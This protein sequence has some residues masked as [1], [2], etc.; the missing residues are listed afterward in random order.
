VIDMNLSPEWSARLASE[1][2][3]AV[4]WRDVGSASASDDAIMDWAADEDRIV[5]TADHDFAAAIATR[6]LAAPSVVQLRTSN[7]DPDG[8]GAFVLQCIS[9]A[10]EELRGGAILT[11]DSG[12]ARLR[13]GPGTFTGE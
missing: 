7:T 5:L 13:R 1:G 9:V 6:A 10:A 2:H 11:I 8:V 3:D 4:H 12:R